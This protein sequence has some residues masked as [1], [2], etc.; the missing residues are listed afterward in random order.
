[1]NAKRLA[2]Q[3]KGDED[4]G[5]RFR[6]DEVEQV[7]RSISRSHHAGTRAASAR[8]A[9]ARPQRLSVGL[10]ATRGICNRQA[11]L[12]RHHLGLSSVHG[13]RGSLEKRHEGTATTTT[14]EA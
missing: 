10:P 8:T 6:S 11:L 2:R 3:S 1:M 5:L 13:Y 4:T 12:R 9:G 14:R 7:S